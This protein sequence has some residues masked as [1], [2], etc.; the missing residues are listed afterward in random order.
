MENS[1]AHNQ[2]RESLSI[3]AAKII[4]LAAHPFVMVILLVFFSSFSGN[5]IYSAGSVLIVLAIVLIP[6]TIYIRSK[7]RK[8]EWGNIDASNKKERPPFYLLTIILLLVLITIISFIPSF[9]FLL[10]GSIAVVVLL[11]LH[12]LL[13]KYIKASLHLSFAS[14]TMLMLMGQ[15]FTYGLLILVVIPVLFWARLI[16]KRHTV[17]EL[18]SGLAAGSA[19][20]AAALLV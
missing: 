3:R 17:P 7:V 13:N 6:L 11:I 15:G 12:A 2:H 16:L 8:K 4:S 5:I 20:A 19:I 18:L 9:A 14:F 10:R 1:A